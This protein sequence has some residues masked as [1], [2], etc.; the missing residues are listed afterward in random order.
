MHAPPPPR[1]KPTE[2]DPRATE[3]LPETDS[4]AIQAGVNSLGGQWRY[5]LTRE[6]TH[7]FV[8]SPSGVSRSPVRAGQPFGGGDADSSQCEQ[9]K[10]EAAIKYGPD[11]GMVALL[12]HWCVN[13]A[14]P[15]EPR[16]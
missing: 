5:E 15:P 1:R 8:V 13:S 7:L 9:P 10:Y 2:A 14:R 4:S 16:S 11:L 6:V 12:P 3:Q